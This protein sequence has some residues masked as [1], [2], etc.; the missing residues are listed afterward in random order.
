MLV[1][2]EAATYVIFMSHSFS[3]FRVK[4]SSFNNFDLQSIM[5]MLLIRN[6]QEGVHMV[7]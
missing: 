7:R 6:Q 5:H 1:E 4:K 3:N 2:P